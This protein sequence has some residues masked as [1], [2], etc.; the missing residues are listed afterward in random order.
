M[1]INTRIRKK[2][3][4]GMIMRFQGVQAILN[5]YGYKDPTKYYCLIGYWSHKLNIINNQ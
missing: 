1:K 5:H 3:I 4:K 2:V